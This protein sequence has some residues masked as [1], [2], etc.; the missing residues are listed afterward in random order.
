MA[1]Q[2]M[3]PVDE[4]PNAMRL[5]WSGPYAWPGFESQNG[6]PALPKHS[7][8]YLWTFPYQD[9]FLIYAAGVTRRL[10]RE[11]FTEHKREFLRGAYNVFDPVQ[12]G[13]GVRRTSGAA[14]AIGAPMVMNSPRVETRYRRPRCGNS[15]PSA[16]S[17]RTSNRRAARRNAWR[18]PSC[19]AFMLHRRHFAIS[20]TKT[21]FWL[22]D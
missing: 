6:L 16:S 15:L 20:P 13:N 9:G 5:I 19:A 7:G 12:A 22:R 11:R 4:P 1:E 21:C 18:R 2:E 14:L 10:F 3:I 8:V 17:W